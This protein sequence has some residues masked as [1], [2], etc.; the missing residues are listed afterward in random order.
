M[1]QFIDTGTVQVHRLGNFFKA[2]MLV[3]CSVLFITRNSR[4]YRSALI[5]NSKRKGRMVPP[6]RKTFSLAYCLLQAKGPIYKQKLGKWPN[7]L[8]RTIQKKNL[9][10]YQNASK[11]EINY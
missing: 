6:Q 10:N 9:E 2:K 7:S 11:E 3:F 1:E 5:G 4:V 8:Q